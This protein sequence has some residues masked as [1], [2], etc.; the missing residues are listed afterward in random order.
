[1]NG[2]LGGVQ[3]GYNWQLDRNWVVSLEADIQGT[4]E[5]GR[6]TDA[7]GSIRIGTIGIMASSASGTDFPWF[8]TFRGRVGFLADPSLLLYG[9]LIGA[10]PLARPQL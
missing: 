7:L 3:I 2:G 9:A 8:A 5:R 6:S 1:V 4:G 10:V